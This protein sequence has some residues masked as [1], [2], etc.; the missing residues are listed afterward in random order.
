MQ[1]SSQEM[2]LPPVFGL[3]GTVKRGGRDKDDVY[4]MSFSRNLKQN[5]F[6][7]LEKKHI[8]YLA[9]VSV[10]GAFH[11]PLF[12]CS[13]RCKH[14]QQRWLFVLKSEHSFLCLLFDSRR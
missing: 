5:M 12:I 3:G 9:A 4:K 14:Q 7:V 2:I 8:S 13:A 1:S 6:V 11:L 10:P